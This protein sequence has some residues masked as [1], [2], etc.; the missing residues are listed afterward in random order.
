[1]P[2]EFKDQLGIRQPSI[3]PENS[4]ECVR[5]TREQV[6]QLLE[7]A[8]KYRAADEYAVAVARIEEALFLDPSNP[9]LYISW[10]LTAWQRDFQL[11]EAFRHLD[12]AVRLAGEQQDKRL[13]IEALMHEVRLACYKK[14]Y[15]LALGVIQRILAVNDCQE[16]AL[17]YLALCF[18]RLDDV[19]QMNETLRKLLPRSATYREKV[20]V[21]DAF[22]PYREEIKVYLKTLR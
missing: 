11:Q 5:G 8:E 12:R 19:R 4:I 7:Q 13:M 9:R 1:M 22:A 17:Y 21:E 14:S 15:D 16:E 20:L 10:G 3:F 6:L 18:C 2:E